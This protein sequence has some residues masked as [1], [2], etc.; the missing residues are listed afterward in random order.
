MQDQVSGR[1]RK[2]NGGRVAARPTIHDVAADAGVSAMSV[3]RV[4]NGGGN[5]S[6]EMTRR[7]LRSVKKLGYSRNENARSI[8]PGQRSGLIG[9][10]VTN[11]D[12][13]YYA[14]VVLGVEDGMDKAGRR[15]LIGTSHGDVTKE[16]TL[17]RDFL[18]R[19]VEGL[20]VVPTGGDEGFLDPAKL[21]GVPIVLA[22]R[23]QPKVGADTVVIDDVGGTVRGVAELISRG[24]RR[25]GFLGND[26]SVST[27]QRRFEGFTQALRDAGLSVADDLVRRDC[28]DV[29]SAR[30]AT[31]GLMALANPPTAVV[32][33][34]NQVSVGAL[35]VLV[36]HHRAHPNVP[37]V[38]LLG[39]DDFTMSEL[40]QHP[41][42]IIDHDGRE[43]GQAAAELLRVRLEGLGGPGPMRLLMPTVVRRLV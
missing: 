11:I 22:S 33:A 20:V 41:L 4:L 34:N 2:G 3:S 15:I 30:E 1:G 7:V 37:P 9:L 12:N 26:A 21:G 31:M 28:R 40:I 13:P 24:H 8:R 35:L 19:Q 43:L 14:Q 23:E 29:E 42:T 10:I 6:A 5:V 18:G 32:C 27:S 36:P 17:V 38:E 25:I 39:V 16:R